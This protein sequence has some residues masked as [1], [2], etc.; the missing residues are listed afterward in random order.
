MQD[1]FCNSP[2]FLLDI[3]AVVHGGGASAHR[4]PAKH[5][6][7]KEGLLQNLPFPLGHKI[8][9]PLSDLFCAC[10]REPQNTHNTQ[11]T[12]KGCFLS[13]S[14]NYLCS[15]KK[16]GIFF[17]LCVFC[18]VCVPSAGRRE[19][20]NPVNQW[21][22]Q[23]HKRKRGCCHLPNELLQQ[24]LLLNFVF[25]TVL[26]SAQKRWRCGDIDMEP[27]DGELPGMEGLRGEDE[28]FPVLWLQRAGGE[29]QEDPVVHAI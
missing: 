8:Q 24:P 29:F 12:H 28:P 23:E 2:F 15:K 10:R 11:N 16:K 9:T 18:V 17:V 7:K 3:C 19:M 1:L 13:F 22:P 20:T 26:E 21:I 25:S 14:L 6:P 4:T 27:G 5:P